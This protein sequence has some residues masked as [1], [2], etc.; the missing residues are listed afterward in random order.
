MLK[1][2]WDGS[3]CSFKRPVLELVIGLG[4]TT[5]FSHHTNP[6]SV[7]NSVFSCLSY[8]EAALGLDVVQEAE[9]R[10]DVAEGTG[11]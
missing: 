6:S 1:T 11:N 8:H 2:K 10:G 5:S 4:E 9:G 7:H 3:K